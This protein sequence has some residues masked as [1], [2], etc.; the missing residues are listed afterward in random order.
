MTEPERDPTHAPALRAS[1]LLRL[2]ALVAFFAAVMAVLVAP[3]LRGLAKDVIVEPS[4]QLSWTLAYMMSGLLMTAIVMASFEL[5]QSLRL[6]SG[7]KAVVVLGAGAVMALAAPALA[8]PL[9]TGVSAALA[10][11]AAI[12]ALAGAW[13]GFRASHTRAVALVMASFAVAGLLRV[14][15]WFVAKNAGDAGNTRLYAVACGIATAAVA[16]EALGQMVAAAWLG[17]R[18][19]FGGQV[20]SSVAIGMAWIITRSASHGASVSATWWEAGLHTALAT[21]SGL[22]QPFGPPVFTAFLLAASILLAGVA[23]V[24][25]RQ[26]VAVIAALSLSLLARG[27]FDIPLHA[28]AAAAAG[29]WITVAVSDQRAMWRS[30]LEGREGGREVRGSRPPTRPQR[31][32][33]PAG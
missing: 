27:A 24:Q 23:A 8:R 18:S 32:A 15:A 6:G 22:P 30:L 26:V 10:T 20:L 5:T 7:A 25:R 29:L 21:A 33:A 31:P 3:G 4:N 2:T 14:I 19:R 11:A 9:P 1:L 28:L 13:Q 12:S 16:F 17:T